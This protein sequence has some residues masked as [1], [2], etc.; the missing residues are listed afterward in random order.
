MKILTFS[1]V[2]HW[3]HSTK[4]PAV[5]KAQPSLRLPPPSS[6]IGAVCMPL[7]REMGLGE[8]IYDGESLSSSTAFFAKLFIAA[9]A[10]FR[11]SSCYWEDINRTL[12][13]QFQQPPRRGNP[14]YTFGAIPFGKVYCSGASIDFALLVDEATARDLLGDSWEGKIQLAA[15]QVSRIG[16]RE[17][18]VSTS[19]V[20]LLE[21]T[22]NTLNKVETDFYFPADAA[23]PIPGSG[24]H[25]EN[26]WETVWAFGS[27]AK[28]VTYIVPGL[29]SLRAATPISVTPRWTAYIADDV[30]LFEKAG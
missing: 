22:K 15:W 1:A 9:S 16:S 24:F 7:A 14:N 5:S 19:H 18:I 13:L 29:S 4:L 6:I 10:R 25:H 23:V 11:G 30:T 17:S 8:V 3:G 2:F 20:K 27:D 26:F 28:Q 12:I 21:T